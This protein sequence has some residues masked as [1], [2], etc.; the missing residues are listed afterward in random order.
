MSATFG[1]GYLVWA[2]LVVA[3]GI[4][5]RRWYASSRD[6]AELVFWIMFLLLCPPLAIVVYLILKM[7]RIG[8]TVRTENSSH[9]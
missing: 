5:F 4:V 2:A 7:L 9:G 8:I 6:R 1:L 3:A